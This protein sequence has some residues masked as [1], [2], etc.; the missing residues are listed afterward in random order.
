MTNDRRTP[1]RRARRVFL[2]GM[3]VIVIPASLVVALIYMA[4]LMNSMGFDT[5]DFITESGAVV[6]AALALVAV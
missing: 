4:H 1:T 5:K 6:L 2:I 3:F